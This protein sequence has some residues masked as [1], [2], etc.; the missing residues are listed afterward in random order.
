[1]RKDYIYRRRKK[2]WREG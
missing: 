2:N 1:M